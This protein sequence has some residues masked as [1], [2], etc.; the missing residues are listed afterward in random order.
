MKYITHCQITPNENALAV[1]LLKNSDKSINI[2]VYD[3]TKPAEMK[4]ILS[5]AMPPNEK[6]EFIDFSAN[7]KFLMAKFQ[8]GKTIGQ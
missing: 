3:I 4:L 5:L 6:I 8:S 7:N 2:E 1:G